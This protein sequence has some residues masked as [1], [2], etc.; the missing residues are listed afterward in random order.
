MMRLAFLYDKRLTQP[1][2]L[3]AF[4]GCIATTCPVTDCTVLLRWGNPEGPDNISQ[5]VLNRKQPLKNSLDKEKV[6]DILKLNRI[7]RPRFVSPSPASPYPLVGKWNNLTSGNG[8]EAVIQTY[9]KALVSGADFFVEHVNTVKKY[10][11]YFFD[12]NSFWVTKKVAVKTNTPRNNITPSWVYEEI[13]LDLDRD[14]V[15]TCL[16]A[17]RAIYILGLDFGMVHAAIDTKGRPVILDITP[18]PVLPLKAINL[19]SGQV[20]KFTADITRQITDSGSLLD[21]RIVLG[22]DPEFMLKDPKTGKIVYP[23]DFLSMDGPL[24]YDERSENRAGRLYP[25]AEVRPVPD[26]CPLNLVKK[27]KGI[28]KQAVSLIPPDIEWLAGSLPFENYQIGGHIH[29]SNIGINCR[30]IRALDNYLAIPLM[31]MED[32]GKSSKR[33]RQY[34]WLGSIR[35]KPHGGFEY[36]TPGSWLVSPE[37]AEGCLCLAKIVATEYRLLTRDYFSDIELQ[38]AFY[39]SKKYYFYD[40]FNEIWEDLKKTQLFSKYSTYLNPIADLINR[41]GHWDET[42][43]I[44]KSWNLLPPP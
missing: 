26:Q 13:P 12:L 27:I 19:F 14:T 4:D 41:G 22:A 6:F 35:P 18:V 33:R 25:L 5:A 44:R 3:N 11:I 42:C 39:Q 10:N 40:I 8:R 31:L 15:K 23:S 37:M 17:Q 38:K 30:L 9:D 1:E 29:F 43:D 34:G 24:G 7:R 16:L 32:P 21:N 2:L 28:L 20:K 36:R